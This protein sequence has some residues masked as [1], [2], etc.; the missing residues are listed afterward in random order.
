MKMLWKKKETAKSRRWVL[1]HSIVFSLV[2]RSHVSSVWV[3][4]V[5]SPFR[6]A[7]TI[8]IGF[9]Y[10]CEFAMHRITCPHRPRTVHAIF[11]LWTKAPDDERKK[12]FFFLVTFARARIHV[13]SCAGAF[14]SIYLSIVDWNVVKSER[15]NLKRRVFFLVFYRYY[16]MV[17]WR[18]PHRI[19]F[20]HITS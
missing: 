6:L 9:E 3:C 10:F 18:P 13:C 14:R 5:K 8:T 12:I 17:A 19:H 1:F 20:L 7:Q 4:M 11:E 16:D 2:F 15:S